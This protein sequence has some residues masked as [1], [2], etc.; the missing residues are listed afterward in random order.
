[1]HDFIKYL[2]ISLQSQEC[3]QRGYKFSP[4]NQFCSLTFLNTNMVSRITGDYILG[5][6]KHQERKAAFC[7]KNTVFN[8]SIK[9]LMSTF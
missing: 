8:S 2:T 7:N 3:L 5:T 1:M 6:V 4:N 9:R